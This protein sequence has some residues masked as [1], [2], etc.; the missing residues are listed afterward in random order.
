MYRTESV[1]LVLQNGGFFPVTI[2]TILLTVHFKTNNKGRGRGIR[3][4]KKRMDGGMGENGEKGEL[5]GRKGDE[6][7][8]EK[9][10]GKGKGKGEGKRKKSEKK[11]ERIKRENGGERGMKNVVGEDVL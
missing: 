6:K 2:D 3:G 8:G 11:R 10:K 9:V 5:R 4:G 7:D 1:F